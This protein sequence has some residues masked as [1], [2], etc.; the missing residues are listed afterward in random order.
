MVQAIPRLRMSDES[1]KKLLEQAREKNR[2]MDAMDRANGFA[3]PQD[4]PIW[5]QLRTA[6]AALEVGIQ[7]YDNNYLAEGY[8]MLEQIEEAIRPP[9]FG[10]R[11]TTTIET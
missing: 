4:C 2:Q 5:E 8:A 9:D 1:F 6:M 11:P 3:A 7:M 10:Q